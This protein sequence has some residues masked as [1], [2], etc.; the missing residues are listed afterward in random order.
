MSCFC[1]FCCGML[2]EFWD[3]YQ[4]S[5]SSIRWK[6]VATIIGNFSTVWI[7]EDWLK[8]ETKCCILTARYL[9]SLETNYIPSPDAVM[10][11][12]TRIYHILLLFLVTLHQ[13]MSWNMMFWHLLGNRLLNYY[14]ESNVN[15]IVCGKHQLAL[16]VNNFE[17]DCATT[18]VN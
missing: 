4:K 12:I 18:N 17:N 3:C 1:L 13:K 5:F 9:K 8:I 15:D 7:A 6:L 11:S 2:Q 10:H 14:Y 16:K